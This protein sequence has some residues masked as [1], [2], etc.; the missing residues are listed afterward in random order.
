MEPRRRRPVVVGRNG[1]E[2]DAILGLREAP[3]K[4]LKV[5]RARVE[6]VVTCREPGWLSVTGSSTSVATHR[7]FTACLL[8]TSDAADE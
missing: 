8:Y 2:F 6:F 1:D 3:D 7:T 4:T 5:D